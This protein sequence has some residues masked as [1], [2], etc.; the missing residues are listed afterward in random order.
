MS[1]VAFAYEKLDRQHQIQVERFVSNLVAKQKNEI[2]RVKRTHEENV[3]L[4]E[5]FMG[6]SHAWDGIDI[7]EYQQ[8]LRGE[9]RE[10]A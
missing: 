3:S 6:R 1:S 5:T 7:L 8:N 4:V 10:N 2:T 9:Y